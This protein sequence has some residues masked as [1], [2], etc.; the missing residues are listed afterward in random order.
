VL[1]YLSQN[2][3]VLFDDSVRELLKILDP[4]E[5]LIEKLACDFKIFHL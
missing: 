3:E 4:L 1:A 5:I 2:Q